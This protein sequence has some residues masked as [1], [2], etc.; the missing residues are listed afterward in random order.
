MRFFFLILFILIPSIVFSQNRCK[1][2]YI[3]NAGFIVELDDKKVLIDG[4]F[5][6]IDGDWCD[7]PS[8]SIVQLMKKAEPPFDNV[9]IIAI[10]HKHSDHFNEDIVVD[11][12]LSNPRTVIICPDQVDQV[13]SETT[14]Y[15]KIN[16]RI[17][18]ITPKPLTDT[19]I[20]ISNTPIRVLRLEHSHYEMKDTVSGKMINKHKDIENL[21]YV[22]NINGIKFFHCGDTNPLNEEEYSAYSLEDEEIDIAFVE[23]LFFGVYQEKAMEMINKFINPDYIILMHINPSN[24][25]FFIEY[26]KQEKNIKV[27]VNKMESIIINIE[28]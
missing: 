8:D 23:R 21:G 13:L 9:D 24:K 7:S 28:D 25:S 5:N 20:T 11:H 14:E 18:S 4:L 22:F 2:T 6:N 17:I 10:S 3:S 12:M 1:I 16:N 27:F 26:L 15:G 19:I